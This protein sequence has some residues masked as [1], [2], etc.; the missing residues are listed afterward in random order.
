[1]KKKHTRTWWWCKPLDREGDK[2]AFWLT[3]SSYFYLLY[4]KI[5]TNIYGFM[6][7]NR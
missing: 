5:K 6:K 7:I 4:K 3:S 1:M 2:I